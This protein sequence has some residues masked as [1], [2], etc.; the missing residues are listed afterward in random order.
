MQNISSSIH[1]YRALLTSMC[2]LCFSLYTQLHGR[3]LFGP[4]DINRVVA[5]ALEMHSGHI[6]VCGVFLFFA[7]IKTLKTDQQKKTD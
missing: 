5:N 1:V 6:V 7:Y 3:V 2:F 4:I